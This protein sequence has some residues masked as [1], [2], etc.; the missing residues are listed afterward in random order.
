VFGVNGFVIGP[1]IAALFVTV[2]EIFGGSRKTA[3]VGEQL[4]IPSAQSVIPSE[5]RDPV[6]VPEMPGQDPSLRSG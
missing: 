3:V 4:L 2:W 1:V 6:G 5:A